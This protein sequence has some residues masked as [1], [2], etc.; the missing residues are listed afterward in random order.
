LNGELSGIFKR[1]YPDLAMKTEE[2]SLAACP[3]GSPCSRGYTPSDFS[4]TTLDQTELEALF[5]ELEL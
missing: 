1:W 2:I 4:A 3:P 5:K